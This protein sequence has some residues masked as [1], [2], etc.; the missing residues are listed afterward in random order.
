[1]FEEK[2]LTKICGFCVSDWHLVTMILPYVNQKIDE[3]AKVS[4][5]LEKD[6]EKNITTLLE[7]LNLE[8]KEKILK[9]NW[10]KNDQIKNAINGMQKGQEIIIIINGS[11]EFIDKQNMKIEKYYSSHLMTNNIRI[12]NCYQIV[13][14][15]GSIT[16]VLDKHDKIINTSGE[17]E[18]TDIFEDYKRKD[19]KQA[20]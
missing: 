20:I 6:L 10:H 13:E 14:F 2:T 15:E 9:I 11:K 18:I 8:N 19:R 7:K 1:M 17:K 4:T 12:I 3:K 5:I 16:Q